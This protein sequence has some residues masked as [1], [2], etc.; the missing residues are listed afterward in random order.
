MAGVA[1]SSVVAASR[2][3]GPRVAREEIS[4]P[5]GPVMRRVLPSLSLALAACTSQSG[6]PKAGVAEARGAPAQPELARGLSRKFQA[7]RDV[8]ALP[9]GPPTQ[10]QTDLG[11]MLFFDERLS[12]DRDV[13]CNTCHPLDRFGVDNQRTSK[14]TAGARGRRNAPSVYHAAGEFTLFW[15]GR[16]YSVEDQ[17]RGPIL[18]ATEMAMPDEASV[19]ARL[20]AI[21]GYPP[22]FRAAF[23]DDLV[24]LSFDNVVRAV[25]AFERKL[26]APSRWDRFIRGNRHV[27]TQQEVSGLKLF[28]DLGC[29]AC[30]NGELVGGAMFQKI[31]LG[32]AWPN[33]DD[34]GRY[35][36]TQLPSDRMV[37]KVPSLRNV[38]RTAPY[39]HDGSAATLD[40][41]V[42]VMAHYQVGEELSEAE[43]AA[44]VSFLGALKGELPAGYIAPPALP[45]D[46]ES[47]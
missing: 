38:A 39:F 22:A 44:I 30:H 47:R 23:P 34:Q 6:Q 37:F 3:R 40:Q 31:G 32:A 25:G 24:A 15:D 9:G 28:L 43:V 45:P 2:H 14:G 10:A 29:I 33:Q 17:A 18:N 8:F 20:A 11:R 7:V 5:P 16:A 19:V 27:L 41:A 4:H 13:A 42:V 12:R 21:P 46:G 36:V 35:E 1:E 26:I